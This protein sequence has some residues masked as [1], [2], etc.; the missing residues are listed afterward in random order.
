MLQIRML[1]IKMPSIVY[2]ALVLLLGYA[3]EICKTL[4]DLLCLPSS[5]ENILTVLLRR[6]PYWKLAYANNVSPYATKI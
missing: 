5:E 4:A 1:I 3:E 2:L 6:R